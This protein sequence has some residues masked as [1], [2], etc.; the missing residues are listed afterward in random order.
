MVGRKVDRLTLDGRVETIA[1]VACRPSRLGFLPDGT[2]LVA[3]MRDRRVLRLENGIPVC[4]ADLSHLASGDINDIV[5][6]RRG[7]AYVGSSNWQA[8][9]HNCFKE[10]RLILITPQGKARVVASDLAFPN[11]CIITPDQ[12]RPVLADTF[13]CRLTTCLDAGGAVWVAATNRPIFVRVLEGERITRVVKVPNR[14]AVACTLGGAKPSDALLYDGRNGIR[15]RREISADSPSADGDT[16][17][18]I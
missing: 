3:S 15:G 5:V 9:A 13:G 18:A 12:T 4:H 6:D 10:A 7:R 17:G 8:G 14:Q 16:C 11:G 1:E 2:L